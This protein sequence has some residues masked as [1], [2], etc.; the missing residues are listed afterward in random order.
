MSDASWNFSVNPDP[1]KCV[2]Q[3]ANNSPQ[4]GAPVSIDSK[5]KLRG[6]LIT[7]KVQN[8]KKDEHGCKSEK[9]NLNINDAKDITTQE[10]KSAKSTN[11]SFVEAVVNPLGSPDVTKTMDVLTKGIGDAIKFGNAAVSNGRIS[12]PNDFKT[13]IVLNVAVSVS[14]ARI[15]HPEM[16]NDRVKLLQMPVNTFGKMARR[17]YSANPSEHKAWICKNPTQMQIPVGFTND[18]KDYLWKNLG[19][20]VNENNDGRATFLYYSSND[21]QPIELSLSDIEEILGHLMNIQDNDDLFNL[22]NSIGNKLNDLIQQEK[23]KSKVNT[24]NKL[25]KK[26]KPEGE[27]GKTKG[28]DQEKTLEFKIVINEKEYLKKEK[29][30]SSDTNSILKAA[31]RRKEEEIYHEKKLKQIDQSRQQENAEK[32]SKLTDDTVKKIRESA[33]LN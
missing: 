18:E 22:A 6:I 27:G 8:D 33:K 9:P 26:D 14:R 20:R 11:I 30:P 4:G 16:G 21:S 12:L 28:N 32:A 23:D 2:P 10:S 25:K 1:V 31:E 15:D 5:A 29:S 19:I 17:M 24:E 7:D 13:S 3:E